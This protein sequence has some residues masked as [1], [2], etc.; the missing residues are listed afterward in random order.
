[1]NDILADNK[2]ANV[3]NGLMRKISK[4]AVADGQ[5][6]QLQQPRSSGAIQHQERANSIKNITKMVVFQAL[7]NVIG[8]FTYIIYYI[9]NNSKLVPVTSDHFTNFLNVSFI[10]LYC[11]PGLNIFIYYFFNKLYNEILNRYFKKIFFFI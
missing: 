9:L 10:F 3:N 5:P 6:Q 11:T 4:Y 1:M 8:T 7:L 2:I